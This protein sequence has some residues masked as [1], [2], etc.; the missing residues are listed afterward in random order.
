M[1][2]DNYKLKI[3]RGFTLIETIIYIALFSVIISLVIGAVYPIIQGSESL[4][5][6]IVADAEAHFLT[7]KIEW[8][9]TSVLAINSPTSGLT[10]A[11]LS[12]DKVNYPQNPILFDL[13]SGSL[14]IKNGLGDPI[15]LNSANVTVSDL[16]F[17]HL[18]AGLYRP[19]AI[20]TSFKVDGELYS[21]T[22]YLR[23]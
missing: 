4:Q 6:N 2:I 13:D 21:T 10:G 5:K 17:Q 3:V 1:K 7:R 19:A 11:T 8:A 12:V 20:K 16:Q 23:K 15:I 14:R 22:I 18:A 9:L